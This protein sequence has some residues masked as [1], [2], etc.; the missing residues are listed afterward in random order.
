MYLTDNSSPFVPGARP[1]NSSDASTLMWSRMGAD[2]I[3]GMAETG[4]GADA[5]GAEAGVVELFGWLLHPP[6]QT[7][8]AL[9]TSSLRMSSIVPRQAGP[10][11]DDGLSLPLAA[12]RR[13][14]D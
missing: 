7:T 8:S 14:R 3:F 6:K 10:F 5:G 12:N 13:P 11:T 2:S 9:S 1:S 4:I